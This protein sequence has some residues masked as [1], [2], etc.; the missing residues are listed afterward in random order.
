MT[1]YVYKATRARRSVTW[2]LVSEHEDLPAAEAAA[3]DLCPRKEPIY[4]EPGNGLDRGFF[5]S[6]LSEKWSAMIT[7]KP[8]HQ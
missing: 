1:Y 8:E 6:S 7:T 5:S 4:T 3:R 2:D